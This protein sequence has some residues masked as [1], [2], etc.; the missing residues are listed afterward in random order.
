MTMMSNKTIATMSAIMHI[1]MRP[2]FCVFSAACT[3]FTPSST[4][5]AVCGADGGKGLG[6]LV[7]DMETQGNAPGTIDTRPTYA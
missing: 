4:L 6:A 1:I 7:Q 5:T 2:I 3:C